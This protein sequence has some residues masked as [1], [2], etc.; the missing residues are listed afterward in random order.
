ME[1]S[2]H[3]STKLKS[4][5]LQG[6][7]TPGEALAVAAHLAFCE[8]CRNDPAMEE[9]AAAT[10]GPL[11]SCGGPQ[12]IVEALANQGSRGLPKVPDCINGGAWRRIVK[13]VRALPL[14]GVSGLGEAVYLIKAKARARLMLPAGAAIVAILGGR[15]QVG[16]GVYGPGDV[17]ELDPSLRDLARGGAA[18][19]CV[20][21]VI[22]DD[23]MYSTEAPLNE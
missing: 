12:A 17:V 9:S 14:R 6:M 5:Y 3:L 22:G 1:T 11:G 10:S 13:D 7:T 4:T 18:A 23:E 15:I 2:E 20:C 16:A 19:G 21:L 8:H